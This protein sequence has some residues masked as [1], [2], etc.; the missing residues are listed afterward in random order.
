[1]SKIK[2]EKPYYTDEYT[3]LD[4]KYRYKYQLQYSIFTQYNY[5][6]NY[7]TGN[8]YFTSRPQIKYPL[9]FESRPE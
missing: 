7:V 8:S 3:S 9:L 6:D 1:M 2:F 4:I 5:L